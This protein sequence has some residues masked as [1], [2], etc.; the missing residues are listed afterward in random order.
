VHTRTPQA[1]FVRQ[2]FTEAAVETARELGVRLVTLDEMK[3]TFAA[4]YDA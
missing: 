2:G 4:V 3:Q 1:L